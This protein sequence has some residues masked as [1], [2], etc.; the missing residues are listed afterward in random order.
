MDTA[1][2]RAIRLRRISLSTKLAKRSSKLQIK[3][4]KEIIKA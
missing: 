2:S 3:A 1:N 4:A